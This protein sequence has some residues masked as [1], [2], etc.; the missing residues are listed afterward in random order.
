MEG[1]KQLWEHMQSMDRTSEKV[2]YGAG[3]ATGTVGIAAGVA[4][5]TK[6]AFDWIVDRYDE[7][8]TRAIERI[9]RKVE[10]KRSTGSNA[11][12]EEMLSESKSDVI[13]SCYHSSIF[14]CEWINNFSLVNQFGVIH[15]GN[16]GCKSQDFKV[17]VVMANMYPM[18]A[19][20]IDL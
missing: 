9:L 17:M 14:I 5:G 18:I 12:S 4:F 1:I 6:I 7:V 11:V 3:V 20:L 2:A 8:E 19:M 10:M 16:K 13:L 15:D